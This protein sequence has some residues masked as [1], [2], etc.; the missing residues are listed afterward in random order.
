MENGSYGVHLFVS[1][2]MACKFVYAHFT[3][4]ILHSNYRN[5]EKKTKKGIEREQVTQGNNLSF[6]G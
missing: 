6:R 3:R 4:N 1:L 2:Q 5:E